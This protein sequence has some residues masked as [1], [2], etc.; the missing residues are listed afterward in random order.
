MTGAFL[1]EPQTLT[2]VSPTAAPAGTLSA[3][4]TRFQVVGL[5]AIDEPPLQERKAPELLNHDTVTCAIAPARAFTSDA[6]V[7]VSP[8]LTGSRGS[9]MRVVVAVEYVRAAQE[10]ATWSLTGTRVSPLPPS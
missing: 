10:A 4:E 8:A 9:R 6:N 1:A 5:V 3:A 7:Q 2:T